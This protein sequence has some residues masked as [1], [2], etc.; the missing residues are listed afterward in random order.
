MYD[1]SCLWRPR[2]RNWTVEWLA[3]GLTNGVIILIT[4]SK[5]VFAP[6]LPPV[7]TVMGAVPAVLRWPACEANIS[8][9]VT[10]TRMQTALLSF[11]LRPYC[12]ITQNKN[13]KCFPSANIFHQFQLL[14][15]ESMFSKL[16][17]CKFKRR[18]YCWYY[19]LAACGVTITTQ[20]KNTW[21]E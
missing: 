7:Q 12:V 11:P 4:M 1:S 14:Y 2:L 13:E 16:V 20:Y 19:R 17:R 18:C 5:S 21:I 8:H 10:R 6:T 15:H 3:T 9:V